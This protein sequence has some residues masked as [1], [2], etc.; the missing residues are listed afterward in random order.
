MGQQD[1]FVS[2][3]D[4]AF[5]K[6]SAEMASIVDALD[7]TT[8]QRPILKVWEVCRATG[9]SAGVVYRWIEAGNF[10]VLDATSKDRSQWR[11]FRSSFLAFLQTRIILGGDSAR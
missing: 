8:D 9:L 7:R 4:A 1:F 2:Q 10:S 6:S 5:R 3:E 11:I